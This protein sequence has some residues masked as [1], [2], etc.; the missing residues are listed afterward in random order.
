MFPVTSVFA[1]IS[2]FI[3]VAL[4]L[5]TIRTR[6]SQRVLIGDGDN[7]IMQR[8]IRAQA[9]FVEYVP[10][11]LL[12]MAMLEADDTSGWLLF[13]L[14]IILLAGRISHAY[15]LLVYETKNAELPIEQR[16][17]FRKYGMI[18]T[19]MVILAEGILLLL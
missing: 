13:S 9:N 2:A 16:I 4:S 1:A 5:N 17:P 15:S 8:A 19:L 7:E 10:L 14:G 3:L 11:A 6:Q 12:M 18:A